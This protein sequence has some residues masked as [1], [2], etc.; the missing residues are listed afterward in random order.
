MPKSPGQFF[1]DFIVELN[2]G[3]IVLVEYKMEKMA[4]HPDE[5]H[6]KAVGELWAERSDGR[7]GFAWIV[8]CDWATLARILE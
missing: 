1:P 5:Q 3:R 4:F 7:A 2:D 6:K 8:N